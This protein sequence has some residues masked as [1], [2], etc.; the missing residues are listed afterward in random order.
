MVSSPES[1]VSSSLVSDVMTDVASP[2]LSDFDNSDLGGD[3]DL[4]GSAGAEAP[5]TK[6]S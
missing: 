4:L 5:K 3:G 1:S 6:K 2:L